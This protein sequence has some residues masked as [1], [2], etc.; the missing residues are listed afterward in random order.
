MR[1]NALQ[2]ALQQKVQ[3]R[4]EKAAIITEITAIINEQLEEHYYKTFS[5]PAHRRVFF[6]QQ[7]EGISVHTSKRDI[8][9]TLTELAPVLVHCTNRFILFFDDSEIRE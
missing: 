1:K 8:L 5:I 9:E 4:R 6:T 2:Q 7:Q 3:Q